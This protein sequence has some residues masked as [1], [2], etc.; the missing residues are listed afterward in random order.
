MTNK[1]SS[2]KNLQTQTSDSPTVLPASPFYSRF[3]TPYGPKLRVSMDF[4]DQPSLT[5][6]SFKNE[7]DI[8][9]I[10]A[11]YL[12]TGVIDF[13]QKHA[14]RYGDATGADFQDAMLIV[15]ESRSMFNDLPANLRNRF[16]NDPA[17]FLDFVHDEANREEMAELGLLKPA[18]RPLGS[19]PAPT[20]IPSASAQP[21]AANAALDASKPAPE[22]AEKPKA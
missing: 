3:V 15:A 17:L 22:G 18:Q 7:C 20:P 2:N 21:G 13:A 6:Q 10:M 19:A 5:K 16:N 12:K 9:V 11:Q 1:N 14:P 8:N 4:T